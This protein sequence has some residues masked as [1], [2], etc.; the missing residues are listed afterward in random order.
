MSNLIFSFESDE[1][2]IDWI[3]KSKEHIEFLGA[4]DPQYRYDRITIIQSLKDGDTYVRLEYQHAMEKGHKHAFFFMKLKEFLDL[5][6][7][8]RD[9]VE[10]KYDAWKQG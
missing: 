4:L 3:N 7:P 10:K 5:N 2:D 8:L 6:E 9:M 1:I